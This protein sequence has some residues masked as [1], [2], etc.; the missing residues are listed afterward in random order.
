MIFSFLEPTGACARA[1]DLPNTDNCTYHGARL[2][3]REAYLA[4][5]ARV[6]ELLPR[7]ASS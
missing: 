6:R 4:L 2:L 5:I 1:L 7:A 3:A